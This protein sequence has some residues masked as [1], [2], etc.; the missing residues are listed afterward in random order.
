MTW[1]AVSDHDGH[2]FAEHGLDAPLN[3]PSLIGDAPDALLVKGSLVIETRLPVS[4][5]PRHLVYYM[6][7]GDWALHL[8]LQA[9][10]G[11]GLTLVLEQG[12]EVLHQT[13][14]HS[15]TGR[16]DVLRITYSWDAPGRWGQLALERTDQDTV[17]LIPVPSPKPL[18]VADAKALMHASPNRYLAPDVLFLALSNEIEPVGPMPS[19]VPDTPIATPTGYRAA[20]DL[21]RGDL[22]VT[23][24]GHSVPVLHTLSRTVPARGCFSP[25]QLRAPYFGLQQGI[26]VAPSQR[27][28]LSGSE[29]EYL[30]GQE[31]VLIPVRHLLGGTA[32]VPAK[33]DTLVTYTQLLLPRHETLLAAGTAVESLYIGRL[34]RNKAR[35]KASLFAPLDRSTLPEH[36]RSV[37]PVLKAFDAIVLSEHRAA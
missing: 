10:P 15:E 4:H 14:N 33:S 32:V 13:L 28:V 30:F 2:R 25:V 3:A 31:S 20:G 23:A 21:R 1:I 24:E 22:V 35:L 18:R 36:G 16:T 12:G 26:C 17:L 6:C 29:V 8:S 19:L 9:V 27:L 34:R 11:G 37:F 5:R 7:E